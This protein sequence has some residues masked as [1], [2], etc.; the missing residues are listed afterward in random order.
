MQNYVNRINKIPLSFLE[1]LNF[2][3]F[4]QTKIKRNDTKQ[5]NEINK[6]DFNELDRSSETK[7]LED[8]GF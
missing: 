5:E 4:K 6:R 1:S 2:V 8:C 3:K 7:V